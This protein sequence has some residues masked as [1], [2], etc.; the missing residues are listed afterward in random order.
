VTMFL[1]GED[2][3]GFK[4]VAQDFADFCEASF[5]FFTD[6][7]SYFVVPAGIFH[8]HERPSLLLL[9]RDKLGTALR[10]RAKRAIIA[11]Q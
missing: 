4:S 2:Y 8:V 7:G 11:S 9:A 1:D 3:L 10:M 5:Y 6:G